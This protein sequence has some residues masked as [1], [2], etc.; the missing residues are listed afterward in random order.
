M[1]GAFLAQQVVGQP[2]QH[3]KVLGTVPDMHPAA[4]SPKVTA[5]AHRTIATSTPV[6]GMLTA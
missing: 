3:G 4:P 5:S 1:Q 2:A 6:A